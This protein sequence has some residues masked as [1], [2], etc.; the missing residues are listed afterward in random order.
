[1]FFVCVF[2]MVVAAD[3]SA[4]CDEEVC[5]RAGEVVLLLYQENA[6]WCYI[7]LQNG[8][9]GYL[10]TACFTPV[11]MHTKHIQC[12]NYTLHGLQYTCIC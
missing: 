3:Y 4:D 2:E 12:T 7:R 1:M 5:V 11:F 10:P 9:E 8:K 6:D